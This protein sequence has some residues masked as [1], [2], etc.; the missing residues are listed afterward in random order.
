MIFK[1]ISEDDTWL[2][3]AYEEAMADLGQF[4]GINWTENKPKVYVLPDRKS[5]DEFWGEKTPRWLVGFGGKGMG[6]VYLL[7][8]KNFEKESD[9]SYSEEKYKALLKHELSHC[10]ADILTK[11]YRKPVW[12][13]EGL[14]IYLSGQLEQYKQ[15]EKF[16]SFLD[17]FDK[18]GDKVYSESGF[19]IKALVDKYGKSKM[20][21][22]LK[23]L[24]ERPDEST[25]KNM[26]KDVCGVELDYAA[27]IV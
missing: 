18:Q 4:F 12:L 11:G 26:F 27:F 10:F 14:A 1:L 23:K 9:N 13:S 22:L 5:I 6:G 16:Q 24:V 8:R 19:A 25:F 17:S 21:E 3:K 7:D 2:K 15:P 20:L